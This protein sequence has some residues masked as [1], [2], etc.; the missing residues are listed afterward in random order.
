MSIQEFWYEAI[1]KK[2]RLLGM[3]H[4]KNDE[5]A[6]SKAKHLYGLA[7]IEVHIVEEVI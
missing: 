3:V 4:G 1:D 7:V 6:M 2:G 5:D